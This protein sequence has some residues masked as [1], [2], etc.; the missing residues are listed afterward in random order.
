[1]AEKI[2]DLRWHRSAFTPAELEKLPERPG[3]YILCAAPPEVPKPFQRLGLYNP[4]YIGRT[5]NLKQRIL[6][7]HWKRPSVNIRELRAHFKGELSL[8]YAEAAP[9]EIE[10]VEDAML[11]CFWPSANREINILGSVDLKGF[12]AVLSGKTAVYGKSRSAHYN[13]RRHTS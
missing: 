5:T 9:Q 1:M 4:V 3:I 6:A 7:G 12:D 11:F 13:Q 10:G 2:R 8:W